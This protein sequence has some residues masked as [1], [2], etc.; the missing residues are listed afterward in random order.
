MTYDK[1]K[2]V[3]KSMSDGR[4]IFRFFDWIDDLKELFYYSV[5]KEACFTNFMKAG[6]SFSSLFYHVFDNLVWSNHVG[7]I[8]EYFLGEIKLK[9]LKNSCSLMRNLI[10]L[11]HSSIKLILLIRQFKQNLKENESFFQKKEKTEFNNDLFF[12][13][14]S[15]RNEIINKIKGKLLDII[16]CSLR[17][18]MILSSLRIDFINKIFPPIIPAFCGFI[19]SILSLYKFVKKESKEQEY[20]KSTNDLLASLESEK[21]SKLKLGFGKYDDIEINN[22]NTSNNNKEEDNF[23][24][25]G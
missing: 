5:Y 18:I 2:N 17:I 24:I 23:I 15:E 20:I 8:G 12:A 6:M 16:H 22:N 19:H 21:G 25:Y 4:K 13:V 10:K 9:N 14:I 7:L 11:V 1:L 3:E